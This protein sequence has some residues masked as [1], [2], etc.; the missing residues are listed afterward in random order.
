V[1]WPA[2]V[3]IA[4]LGLVVV[5]LAWVFSSVH[6]F[7]R[8]ET[9][10]GIFFG[11][12]R[13]TQLGIYGAACRRPLRRP[14]Q[15]PANLSIRPRNLSFGNEIL[16]RRSWLGGDPVPTAFYNALS[17][18]FPSGE[19]FFMDSVRQFRD[20][21]TGH[22][23]RQIAA[24]LSQE[25]AHTR[26][27]IIFNRQI[28]AYNP[29]IAAMQVRAEARLKIARTRLPLQQL[30]ETIALEHL[31]AILADALLS[32]YRHLAGAPNNIQAMWRWHAIEEIEHKAV[33][34]DTFVAAT[35]SLSSL[36]RWALRVSTM[37]MSTWQLIATM[38]CNISDSFTIDGIN[39]SA[40]WAR[41]LGYLLVRPGILR[42]ALPEYF[43]Y[44]LP[45]FHPW[46]LDNRALM[47]SAEQGLTKDY[48]K[49][50]AR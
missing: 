2:I 4:Y 32:D 11:L 44:F 9:N 50:A 26:E 24:F 49:G 43:A 3:A 10:R 18:C 8:S 21:A 39:R 45:G 5:E 41:L 34:F 46:R 47:I 15:T 42:Q 38:G 25:A 33:A 27:H 31:T 20:C 14:K 29:S 40:T 37:T 30:G 6:R 35:S 23:R 12:Q 7:E 28:A 16:S 36:R 19:R 13:N 48:F 1:N 17:A 22:L